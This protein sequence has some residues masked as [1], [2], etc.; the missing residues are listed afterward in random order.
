MA[1]VR[2][3]IAYSAADA[4]FCRQ[5]A[6][7]LQSA[8]PDA[9]I[10]F[11]AQMHTDQNYVSRLAFELATRPVFIVL[12]TPRSVS[13]AWVR[14]E[15]TMAIRLRTQRPKERHII[16]VLLEECNPDDLVEFLG[17]FQMVRSV[18]D[19]IAVCCTK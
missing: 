8:L 3:F 2:M 1:A 19:P 9:D 14:E 12:L 15:T 5:F 16:P 6:S 18:D 13:S 11:D 7:C 17:N 4:E 10:F